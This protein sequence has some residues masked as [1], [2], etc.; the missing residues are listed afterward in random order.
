MAKGLHSISY[1]ASCI[2]P[3]HPSPQNDNGLSV[4]DPLSCNLIAY[5]YLDFKY[6]KH[7]WEVIYFA[8]CPQSLSNWLFF[9]K[10]DTNRR[11]CSELY[12]SG[13]VKVQYLPFLC[14]LTA[15]CQWQVFSLK[16]NNTATTDSMASNTVNTVFSCPNLLNT[17]RFNSI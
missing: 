14:N 13:S 9:A 6:S 16:S 17:R 8:C 3:M 5:K 10:K 1:L 12:N 2:Q 4:D 7:W 11:S 15:Y